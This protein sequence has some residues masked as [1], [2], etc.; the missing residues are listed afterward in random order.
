MIKIPV[1]ADFDP[2]TVEAQLQ[3]FQQRLNALGKQIAEANKVQFSPVSDTTV[4]DLKKV[5]AQF[6][7]LKRISG[8]LN[9]RLNATGQK[10]A[11][12]FDVDWEKLYPDPHSRARQMAKAF[13]YVT[14]AQFHAPPPPPGG[15]PIPPGG[16]HPGGR[17]PPTPAAIVGGGAVNVVRAGMDAASGVTGGVTGVASKALG[18]GMRAGVGAGLM[19]LLGGIAA[20]GVGKLIGAATENIGKAEDNLVGLDQLKRQL[21]DVGVAFEALKAS[22]HGAANNVKVTFDEAGR[23][24]TQFAKLGNLS[25]D[26]ALSLDAELRTGVGLSRSL[27]LEPAQGVGFLGSMRGI[28]MTQDEQGSRKLA[29]LIGETIAKSDAFAKA[30]EVM[31]AISGYVQ[32][33]ARVS[34]S[35]SIGGYAGMFAALTSSG[36]PGLDPTGA[37]NMMGRIN[38]A[39]HQGGMKGEASQFVSARV[40]QAMGLNPL[41]TLLWQ[42]SGAF[43]TPDEVF[44]PGSL[45]ERITGQTKTGLGKM[46]WYEGQYEQLRKSYGGDSADDKLLFA[47]ALGEHLGISMTNAMALQGVSPMQMGGLQKMLK[48]VGLDFKDINYAGLT[49]LNK[50]MTGTGDDRMDIA[51]GLWGRTGASA[52]TG[53]ERERLDRVMKEGSASEQREVLAHLVASRDQ[54]QTQGKDIRDSK[55]LLDNVKTLM[56]EQLIPITQQ[57]RDGILYM[58]GVKDGKSPLEIR[59]EVS[60]AGIDAKYAPLIA[61][62]QAFIRDSAKGINPRAMPREEFD[63]WRED[64]DA[65]YKRLADLKKRRKEE[66]AEAREE[67]WR[68]PEKDPEPVRREA[69]PGWKAE[70]DYDER[71]VHRSRFGYGDGAAA[72]GST[73]SELSDIE[74]PEQ[75]A[76]V[77]AFLDVIAESEGAGYNS[78]VGHGTKNSAIKDLSRHPGIIGMW[79]ADGPSTAAGRYQITKTTW[80][81]LSHGG[82]A[83][84]TPEAQ[85]AAAIELLKRRGAWQHVLAGDFVAAAKKLGNEWQSLPTGTSPNQGKRNWSFFD[86]ASEKAL[87]RHSSE[88]TPAPELHN[89]TGYID[90]H[91]ILDA[92]PI[93]VTIRNERGENMAPPQQINPRISSNFYTRGL[94]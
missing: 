69:P 29:I 85:D 39:A 48:D 55:V 35:A 82:K 77:K 5:V 75:R 15:G 12:F 88:G 44:G 33:Q 31:E 7:A 13:Q 79:T 70:D 54:E 19:G 14:G 38:A 73:A 42:E 2:S 6:E 86:R 60:D 91:F 92:A 62:E 83:P 26:Q 76:N 30:D 20:L 53:E 63:K 18:T 37:A 28:G 65:A 68:V 4:D 36:I 80:D 56:A 11:G 64:M 50:V 61:A 74:D 45:Y 9:K 71:N 1:S 66:K 72:L 89:P 3:Q 34:H 27:G 93:D 16:Q 22:V 58:A 67:L 90:H 25:S 81:S 10:G 59:E 24:A 47:N 49:T 78:L 32:T 52:L 43:T 84:F 94:A 41:E 87:N 8:D 21:G 40:G 51:A 57:M 17:Q 23:L 46:T